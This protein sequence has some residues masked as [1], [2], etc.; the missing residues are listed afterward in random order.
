M[1]KGLLSGKGIGEAGPLL[2]VSAGKIRNLH[3]AAS[4]LHRNGTELGK[5]APGGKVIYVH[6]HRKAIESLRD[7]FGYTDAECAR[8][9]DVDR[10]SLS[11][12][13]KNKS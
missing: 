2:P 7:D 12:F 1:L 4:V 11:R 9:L 5:A 10:S 13:L 8:E 6:I 3:C